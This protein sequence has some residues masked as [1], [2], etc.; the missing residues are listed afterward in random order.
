MI[1]LR[2][3]FVKYVLGFLQEFSLLSSL[4][5]GFHLSAIILAAQGMAFGG[6]TAESSIGGEGSGAPREFALNITEFL[7]T[8]ALGFWLLF[9]LFWFFLVFI[10][11]D[12]FSFLGYQN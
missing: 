1:K 9:E 3:F 11:R 7:F 8:L 10:L 2:I 5:H 4:L 6:V 12:F